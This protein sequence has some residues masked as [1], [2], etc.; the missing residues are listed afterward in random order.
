[1]KMPFASSKKESMYYSETR[2][3]NQE[4]M[5]ITIQLDFMDQMDVET[6]MRMEIES[7]SR[8]V[9]PIQRINSN[10]LGRPI[11]PRRIH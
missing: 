3:E 9:M 11:L 7:M 10:I 4:A 1:M 6:M 5:N 8:G 2:T